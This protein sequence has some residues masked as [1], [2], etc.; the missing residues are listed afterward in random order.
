MYEKEEGGTLPH[1]G[2]S[3]HIERNASSSFEFLL[4]DGGPTADDVARSRGSFDDEAVLVELLEDFSDDLPD[5]LKG[6]D[7]LLR[8]GVVLVESLDR[9]AGRFER[10]GKRRVLFQFL[11][12]QGELVR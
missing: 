8:L 5:R 1:D 3:G 2:E 11:S 7:V 10:F 6:F 12:S 4:G 9:L